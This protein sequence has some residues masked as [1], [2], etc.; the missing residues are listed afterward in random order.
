MSAD[1]LALYLL[2]IR[3]VISVDAPEKLTMLGRVRGRIVSMVPI[4][5]VSFNEA[6]S[7][8]PD[9]DNLGSDKP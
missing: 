4:S 6:R 9:I 8:L 1:D 7:Y 2:S 3:Y 5:L